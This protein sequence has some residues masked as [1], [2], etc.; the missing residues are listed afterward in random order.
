MVLDLHVTVLNLQGGKMYEAPKLVRFGQFRDLTLQTSCPTSG[1]GK[2]F[3][4]FDPLYPTGVND[5]CPT[6][7]RS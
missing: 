2:T 7:A 4:N 1:P 6:P 5:G 3:P